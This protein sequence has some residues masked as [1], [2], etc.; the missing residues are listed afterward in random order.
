M[1]YKRWIFCVPISMFLYPLYQSLSLHY[2]A[3]M[4]IDVIVNDISS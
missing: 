2:G 1:K 4:K 3:Q